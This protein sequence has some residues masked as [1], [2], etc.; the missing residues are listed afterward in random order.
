MTI[1]EIAEELNISTYSIR[2]YEKEGLLDVPRSSRG[3]REFD[4]Q[5]ITSLKAILHYRNVGMSLEDIKKIFVNFENHELSIQLLKETK[6]ELD[7]K[8]AELEATREY[9]IYK[10]GL[11]ERIAREKSEKSS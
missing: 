4:E 7:Q 1:G 10:I 3:I 5:S 6:T 11:H 2:F 8:I 9:L